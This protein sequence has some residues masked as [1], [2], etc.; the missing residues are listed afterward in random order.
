MLFAIGAPTVRMV[1]VPPEPNPMASDM[2]SRNCVPL[3]S[4]NCDIGYEPFSPLKADDGTVTL[5][6]G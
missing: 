1:V 2:V 4:G 3:A 5:S 6:R